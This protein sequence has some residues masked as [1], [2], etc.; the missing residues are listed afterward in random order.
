[1]T[2]EIERH[3]G[4]YSQSR[5]AFYISV[6]SHLVIRAKGRCRKRKLDV[7]KPELELE[8]A[9]DILEEVAQMVVADKLE[10]ALLNS[11]V[12]GARQ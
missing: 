7:R 2:R 1:M 8:Q 3:G 12:A 6:A 4:F 9:A 5:V 10:D 11:I